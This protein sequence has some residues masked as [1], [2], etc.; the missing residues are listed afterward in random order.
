MFLEGKLYWPKRFEPLLPNELKSFFSE[1]LRVVRSKLLV[2]FINFFENDVN[3]I[4]F[5]KKQN[6]TTFPMY[7]YP[8]SNKLLWLV[9]IGWWLNFSAFYI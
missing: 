4:V 6:Y 2:E 8:F 1:S 9:P 7:L 5:A 3:T